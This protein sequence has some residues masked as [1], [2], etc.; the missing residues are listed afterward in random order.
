MLSN[1]Q[2]KFWTFDLEPCFL[3]QFNF[4]RNLLLIYFN[5]FHVQ[6]SAAVVLSAMVLQPDLLPSF[7][8]P[9]VFQTTLAGFQGYLKQWVEK[10][11]LNLIFPV[12]SKSFCLIKKFYWFS[13]SRILFV[14]VAVSTSYFQHFSTPHFRTSFSLFISA[15]NKLLSDSVSDR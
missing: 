8:V 9:S 15:Y 1:K 6:L 10:P 4:L 2:S 3:Q 14:A 11:H 5:Y 7:P 12:K 13:I